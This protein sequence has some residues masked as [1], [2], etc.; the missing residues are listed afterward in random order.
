MRVEFIERDDPTGKVCLVLN[1][2]MPPRQGET[3]VLDDDRI[4][5][6]GTIHYED[7]SNLILGA[8]VEVRFTGRVC[9]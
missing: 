2:P 3:V 4:A 9:K 7:H 6:V 5:A 8:T 1:M